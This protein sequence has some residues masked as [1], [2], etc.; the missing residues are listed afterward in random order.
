M[1]IS[2]EIVESK[3]TEHQEVGLSL[4]GHLEELAA[5]YQHIAENLDT[6]DVQFF[7]ADLVTYE[8]NVVTIRIAFGL[9]RAGEDDAALEHLEQIE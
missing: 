4:K 1:D 6:D 3:L 7:E 2:E 5:T 9:W 8:A